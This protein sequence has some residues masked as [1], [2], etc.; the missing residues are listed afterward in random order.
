M[1]PPPAG[2]PRPAEFLVSEIRCG[3]IP[4]T[5]LPLQSGVGDIAN[6]VLAALSNNSEVPVFEMC[7]E[8]LQDSRIRYSR[9]GG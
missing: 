4:R 5:I 9:M 2:E 7:T 8:V 3:R 6:S 1:L